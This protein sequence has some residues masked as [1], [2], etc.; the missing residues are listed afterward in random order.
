MYN[1]ALFRQE[2]PASSEILPF[3]TLS[4]TP[5]EQGY[6]SSWVWQFDVQTPTQDLMLGDLPVTT[7]GGTDYV[8][9]NLDIDEGN[10]RWDRYVSLDSL[11]IYV[12]SEMPPS[13]S[14][15]ADMGDLVWDLDGAET[16]TVLLSGHN[17]VNAMSFYLPAS[18]LD[19]YSITDNLYLYSHFGGLGGDWVTDGGPET[20]AIDART[21]VPRYVPSGGGGGE[22]GPG[23]VPEPVAMPLL[24]AFSVLCAYRPRRSS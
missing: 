6:N 15:P 14:Y 11:Q 24:I 18:L 10:G 5:T 4:G 20:W 8:Y 12:S 21:D 13:P 16:S 2:F 3:L 9:F 19:S 17:S 1:G 22:P 7:I 23:P